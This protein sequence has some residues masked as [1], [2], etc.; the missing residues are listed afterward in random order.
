MKEKHT[1]EQVIEFKKIAKY[2]NDYVIIDFKNQNSL[3]EYFRK[4]SEDLVNIVLPSVIKIAKIDKDISMMKVFTG[5]VINNLVTE[6][7]LTD[8]LKN[9][10]EMQRM[11]VL[12]EF[13]ETIMDALKLIVG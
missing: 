5:L 9:L 11:G 8:V 10:K 4:Q 6:K 13:D 2:F 1:T 12:L 7:K 3:K